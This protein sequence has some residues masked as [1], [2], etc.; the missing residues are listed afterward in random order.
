MAA[1]KKLTGVIRGRTLKGTSQADN[2]LT[3]TFAD[4]SMM[5]IKTDGQKPIDKLNGRT[6]K[7]VQQSGTILTLT[8]SDSSTAE[9]NLVEATSSVMLRDSKGVMEYAD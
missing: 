1:N 9:I 6:V 7:S 4:D 2:L 5:R 3:I 8:F